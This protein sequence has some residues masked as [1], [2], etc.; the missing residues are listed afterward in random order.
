MELLKTLHIS[1]AGMRVQGDRLRVIAENLANASTTAG[2]PG[3]EPYRRK[4]VIFEN[5]LN[6]ALGVTT[7]RTKGTTVDRSAFGRLYDPGHPAADEQ[8]NV[9]LPNVNPMMEMA[10]MR[11][12]LRSYQA[13]LGMIEASKTMVQRTLSILTR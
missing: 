5:V 9:L 6:R 7:V 2:T 3:S 1:A 10:D 13:N 11:E 12:A 4:L 8:G